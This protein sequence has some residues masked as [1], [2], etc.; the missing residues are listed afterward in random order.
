[1]ASAAGNA[2]TFS[3]GVDE[4]ALTQALESLLASAGHGGRWTLI[5]SGEGLER[6]FKFKNFGKTWVY[7]TTH[8]RWTTHNPKGLSAKDVELARLCDALAQDFEEQA[9]PP[10]QQQQPDDDGGGSCDLKQVTDRA[11]GA[12]G[13]CCGNSGGKGGGK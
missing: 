10:Q 4:T 2:V 5:P 8:I 6:S 7:N 3:A 1:M 9:P 11:S 13:D 12:A